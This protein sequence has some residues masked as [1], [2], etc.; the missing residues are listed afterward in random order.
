M[1]KDRTAGA[2]TNLLLSNAGVLGPFGGAR[3]ILDCRD[4]VFVMSYAVEWEPHGRT[5][6]GLP[7]LPRPYPQNW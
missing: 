3:R 6:P 4:E 7:A 1:S 2:G 5:D